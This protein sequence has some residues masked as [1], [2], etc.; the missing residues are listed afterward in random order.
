MIN[1]N[2]FTKQKTRRKFLTDKIPILTTLF[3]NQNK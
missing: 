1:L 2:F 3:N